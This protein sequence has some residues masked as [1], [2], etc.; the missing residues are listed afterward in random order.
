MEADKFKRRLTAIC[1][2]GSNIQIHPCMN[3]FTLAPPLPPLPGENLKSVTD[4]SQTEPFVSFF[5]GDV[6]SNCLLSNHC[7][8]MNEIL[9]LLQNCIMHA[10]KTRTGPD[11]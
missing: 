1:H 3:I 4:K 11:M 9:V 6:L 7:D 2:I 8:G 10:C 5:E